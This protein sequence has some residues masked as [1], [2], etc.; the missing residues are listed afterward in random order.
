MSVRLSFCPSFHICSSMCLIRLLPQLGCH[1]K[2]EIPSYKENQVSL[3]LLKIVSILLLVSN[4]CLWRIIRIEN[5]FDMVFGT[6]FRK[7]G[8]NQKKQS[9]WLFCQ[10]LSSFPIPAFNLVFPLH[11]FVGKWNFQDSFIPSLRSGIKLSLSS[12]IFQL[13]NGGKTR[14]QARKWEI[15]SNFDKIIKEST[16]I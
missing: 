14:F 15:H 1:D 16:I 2:I 9:P 7:Y 5:G 6:G 8:K 11:Y 13:N 10:N 12:F 3:S 4:F